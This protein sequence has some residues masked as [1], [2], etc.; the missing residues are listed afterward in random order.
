MQLHHDANRQL[1]FWP[2]HKFA[3]EP[4]E[5]V[6][7]ST[8]KVQT[9]VAP[10]RRLGPKPA[11]H[12]AGRRSLPI[13]IE[14]QEAP[15]REDHAA[16]LASW[17]QVLKADKGAIFSAASHAQKAADYLTGLQAAPD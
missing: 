5:F 15:P 14:S 12:R 16:Y 17:L 9:L 1:C 2:V 8:E 7:Y 13:T 3:P 10:H 6:A 11:P 4:P